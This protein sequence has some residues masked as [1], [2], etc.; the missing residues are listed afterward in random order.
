VLHGPEPHLYLSYWQSGSTQE[1]DVRLAIRVSG[2]A[3][4]ALTAIRRTIRSIDPAVPI[5]EDML[6]S[7]Q[8]DLE[9]MPVLLARSVMSYCGVLAL[10]L[11]A[12]GIYSLL[13]F[14]VRARTREI[15]IRIAVGARKGDVIRMILRQ[16]VRLTFMGV[17]I[18]LGAAV[19]L[20]RLEG[21]LLYGVRT[22]DPF[23]FAFVTI[24]LFVSAL[25]ASLLPARRA[26]SID[27]T[28]ALRA[29]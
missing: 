5:G 2:D 25:V 29:E 20:T 4:S 28:M 24:V 27:P 3:A 6:M 9:Y 18:G 23:I 10:C 17:F 21:S 22:T 12:I 19:C 7:E 8:V 16:G 14:A 1:G 11:G 15:G 13:A 26:A